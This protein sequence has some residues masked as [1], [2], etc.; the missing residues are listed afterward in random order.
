M[1]IAEEKGRLHEQAAIEAE[2]E[3]SGP[4]RIIR[5]PDDDSPTSAGHIELD[6]R[7]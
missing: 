6:G 4:K 7:R 3:V 5:G 2:T 1:K